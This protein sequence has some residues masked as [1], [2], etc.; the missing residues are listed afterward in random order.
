MNIKMIEKLIFQKNQQNILWL[1]YTPLISF[2]IRFLFLVFDS[3]QCITE[4]ARVGTDVKS[5]T[6]ISIYTKILKTEN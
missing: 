3:L 6:D 4:D 5:L 1:K 2:L